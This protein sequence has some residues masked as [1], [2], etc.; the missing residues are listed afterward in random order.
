VVEDD[1]DDEEVLRV[2]IQSLRAD[3]R[4]ADILLADR[5]QEIRDAVRSRY[6]SFSMLF[7]ECQSLAHASDQDANSPQA[8]ALSSSLLKHHHEL[9]I[10][11]G[12]QSKP[13]TTDFELLVAG[14]EG[15]SDLAGVIWALQRATTVAWW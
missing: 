4:F 10:S 3:R 14:L 2:G 1:D 5:T 13:N 9:E 8:T 15:V 11:S 12:C 6:V 7:A